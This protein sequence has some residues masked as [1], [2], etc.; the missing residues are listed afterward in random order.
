MR[1]RTSDAHMRVDTLVGAFEQLDDYKRYVSGMAKF[2]LPLERRLASLR[3]PETWGAWRPRMI[4]EFLHQDLIDLDLQTEEPPFSDRKIAT[5]AELL[6]VL[7][8]MTGSNLGAQILCKRAHTI[9]LNET[10]GARHLAIQAGGI[11]DWRAFNAQLDRVDPIDMDAVTA[12]A[13]ATFGAAEGAFR[14]ARTAR[15]KDANCRRVSYAV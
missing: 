15:S 2:R 3:W 5:E 4:G 14:D 13:L 11:D 1:E 10:H 12:A 8:V 7:Y 9:G 6:G